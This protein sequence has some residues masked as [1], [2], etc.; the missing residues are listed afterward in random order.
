V[1]HQHDSLRPKDPCPEEGC[2]GKVYLQKE[3]TGVYTSGIVGI[4]GNQKIALLF[5]T[6]NG[7]LVADIFMTIIH[8]CELNKV[9]PFDYM[10]TIAENFEAA[11]ASPMNWLPWNYQQN[12]NRREEWSKQWLF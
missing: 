12:L 1:Q 2:T 9:N 10:V 5:K 6:E 3:R 11:A 4:S 8:T 7:T